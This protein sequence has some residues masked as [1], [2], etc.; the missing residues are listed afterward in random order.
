MGFREVGERVL[1]SVHSITKYSVD[2]TTTLEFTVYVYN[3]H[4]LEDHSIYT[5]RRRSVRGEGVKE[6]L[7]SVENSRLCVGLPK[8]HMMKSVDLNRTITN[9]KIFIPNPF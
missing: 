8:D 2:V 9:P 5:G 6:L 7:S 3:W 1:D 4:L